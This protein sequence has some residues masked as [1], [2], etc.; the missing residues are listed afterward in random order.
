M[1]PPSLPRPLSAVPPQPPPALWAHLAIALLRRSLVGADLPVHLELAP[2]MRA[3]LDAPKSLQD[4]NPSSRRSVVYRPRSNRS[5]SFPLS[6]SS[7]R[8]RSL[9]RCPGCCTKSSSSVAMVQHR[10]RLNPPP[11]RHKT[12]H[13]RRVLAADFALSPTPGC[14]SASSNVSLTP[15]DRLPGSVAAA[16]GD[17]SIRRRSP[18]RRLIA[19]AH[20][21]TG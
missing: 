16:A 11:T 21:P 14:R 19:L 3:Y 4:Y 6:L 10:T 5:T 1:S 18:V 8:P 9:S 17:F 12:V 7:I 13:S 15:A 20:I 2:I